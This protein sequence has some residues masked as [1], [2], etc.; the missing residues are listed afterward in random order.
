MMTLDE[1][2][3]TG[4]DCDDLGAAGALSTARHVAKSLFAECRWPAIC[5]PSRIFDRSCRSY[6]RASFATKLVP[7]AE[8]HPLARGQAA[9]FRVTNVL[10]EHIEKLPLGLRPTARNFR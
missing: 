6:S 2:R 10:A 3:A 9:R 1:F 4:R 5:Y 8:P 7:R